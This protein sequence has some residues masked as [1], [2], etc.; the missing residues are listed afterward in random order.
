V[1]L[2]QRVLKG[3]ARAAARLIS[4]AEDGDP[5][6]RSE[7]E[8]LYPHTGR[9][10]IVGVTGPPGSGKSTLVDRLTERLR[11][12]RKKVGIIAV[13]PSSPFTGGA[14]L[15]DRIRMQ[16]HGTDEGVFIRSMAS[17]GQLGGLSYGTYDAV[18]VL[19][20]FGCEI[21]LLETVGV[22]QDEVD[23]VRTADSVLVLAV[24]GLGD[25]VQVLKAGI[26]EIADILVVGKADLEGAD[27]VERDLRGLQEIKGGEPQEWLLPVLKVEGL[28]G[29]GV[30]E[31]L[32][33]IEEHKEYMSRSREGEAR[34]RQRLEAHLERLLAETLMGQALE[35]LR[36]SG[37]WDDAVARL[38][39]RECAP[40][41]LVEELA[42][43]VLSSPSLR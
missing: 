8:S 32:R 6:A 21:I 28:S 20:A 40:H 34:K 37:K 19:D 39:R 1:S 24:P 43:H 41:K 18:Q 38:G 10:Y 23:I 22:G 3:D 36:R 31:L 14:I 27:Q 9:S 17:R 5:A 15:A 2:A 26:L 12:E 16:R 7:M 11:L 29:V 13:D 42:G 30:A 4:M 33:A 35:I 25:S